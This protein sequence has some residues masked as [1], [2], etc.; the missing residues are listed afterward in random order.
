MITIGCDGHLKTS[1]MTVLNHDGKKIM[2]T[3]LDNDPNELL[4]FVR[5][6]ESPKQFAI[7]TNYNWPVYY[8]LLNSEVDEFHLLHAK[9]LKS[10]IQSQSKC[11]KKDADEI[12]YLTH[13]G[14]I[15]KAHTANAMTRQFRRL[16]RNRIKTAQRVTSIKNQIHSILNT[17]IFYSQKP[18]GFKSIFCRRGLTYLNEVV[19]PGHERFVL[20]CLLEQMDYLNG[21]K[22]KFEEHIQKISFATQQMKLL[23]SVPSMNGRVLNY[24]VLAEIDGIEHFKNSDVLV[25]YAG[26]IPRDK[27]SGSKLRKGKL[28]TECNEFLKWAMLEAVIPAIR[29][30]RGLREYYYAIKKKKNSSAARIA[31]ARRLLRTIYHVLKEQRPY[32][33]FA[34]KETNVDTV[35]VNRG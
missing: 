30:D 19:L 18:K 35:C 2:S 15:P 11:D 23:Q 3:K 21:L 26:L 27:S 33:A 8:D 32:Y 10:I 25:S 16:L 4:E 5:Q 12:S 34:V 9:K 14:Y 28:K 7:E 1:T 31:V 13:V 22:E 24:T 29:K 17:N 20:N 6:F